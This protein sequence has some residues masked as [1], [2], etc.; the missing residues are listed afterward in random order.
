M[1][2][3]AGITALGHVLITGGTGFIGTALT[4]RL[5]HLGSRVS[6][7]TRDRERARVE[8]MIWSPALGPKTNNA[9]L[10]RWS[11]PHLNR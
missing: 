2:G 5:L 4:G 9:W 8:L 11:P 3:Q 10:L 1:T 6:I 7:L